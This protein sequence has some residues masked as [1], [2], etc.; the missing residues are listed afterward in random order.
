MTIMKVSYIDNYEFFKYMIILDIDHVIFPYDGN[1][2]SEK[3][4]H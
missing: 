2:K 3:Y 1:V 4:Y